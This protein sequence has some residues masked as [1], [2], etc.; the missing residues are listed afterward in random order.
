MH[1]EIKLELAGMTD[2]ANGH[3]VRIILRQ[4]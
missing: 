1:E 2:Q 3:K 4:S